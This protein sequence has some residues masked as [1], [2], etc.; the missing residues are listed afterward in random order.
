MAHIENFERK[1]AT[2]VGSKTT[3]IV[4]PLHINKEYGLLSVTLK[5]QL[6]YNILGKYLIF[7]K[8]LIFRYVRKIPDY[9][10][11]AGAP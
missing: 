6:E 5:I 11:V 7:C 8:R 1:K 10:S 9:F 2:I 3:G 4:A